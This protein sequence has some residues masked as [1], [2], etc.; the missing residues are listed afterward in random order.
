MFPN[1]RRLSEIMCF[2]VF[3]VFYKTNMKNSIKKTWLPRASLHSGTFMNIREHFMTNSVSRVRSR[4]VCFFCFFFV[5]EMLWN[6]QKCCEMFWNVV[7]CSEMLWNVQKCCEM[8]RNVVK[9]SEMLWDVQKC[10][11]MF[12]IV[13]ECWELL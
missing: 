12:G 1:V 7:K 10:C 4:L 8:F 9:S 11:G 3:L 5:C 2:F 13:V 6:V